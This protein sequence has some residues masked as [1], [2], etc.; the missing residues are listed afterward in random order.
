MID[1]RIQI[2]KLAQI[3]TL[4]SARSKVGIAELHH[5]RNSG[6]SSLMRA[7]AAGTTESARS[8]ISRHESRSEADPT[9]LGE[10][11]ACGCYNQ[12]KASAMS[13]GKEDDS[14]T[15]DIRER[16]IST[17]GTTISHYAGSLDK[18]SLNTIDTGSYPQAQ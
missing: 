2:A 17:A 10:E 3:E 4:D 5:S 18:A 8:L 11:N 13:S 12:G 14:H 16:S 1:V 9:L 6:Y 7:E 15:L